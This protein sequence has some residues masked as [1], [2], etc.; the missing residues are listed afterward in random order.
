MYLYPKTNELVAAPS[1]APVH[2]P[3]GIDRLF[4]RVVNDDYQAFERIFK[5][6]FKTLCNYSHK[7]VK[8]R[9]IA[10]EIVDDVF[11][12]LWRNRKK[13]Q[14]TSSFQAYLLTSVR[15]KSL[16]NLRKLKHEKNT[17]L[18]SAISVACKQSIAYEK[19][20]FEEL[21][22]HINAAVTRLPTQCR[23]IFLMSREQDLKYKE[24]AHALNISVKT[25]DTQ[26]GRALK[27]LRKEVPVSF[28][29]VS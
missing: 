14:I 25:V 10:E 26:M 17:V 16:D 20:I 15:N 28:F 23:I 22:V 21:T 4:Q 2:Q 3:E 1:A 9:Q 11:F 5:D 27:H 29:N 24:I 7:L 19:L 6:T 13:I 8:S 12:N 18:E